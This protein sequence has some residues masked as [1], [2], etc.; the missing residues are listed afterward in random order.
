MFWASVAT[1]V[2]LFRRHAVG[3]SESGAF[4]ATDPSETQETSSTQQ[5]G[6]DT[7]SR[8][9]LREWPCAESL[10]TD[11]FF[12]EAMS[13]SVTVDQQRR[14][15]QNAMALN[16]PVSENLSVPDNGFKTTEVSWCRFK[17]LGSG[18]IPTRRR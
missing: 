15:E 14:E 4:D 7:I 17:R 10:L 16:S 13:D 5:E 1:I 3:A 6:L 2:R 8:V 9:S 12:S 11:S 18:P